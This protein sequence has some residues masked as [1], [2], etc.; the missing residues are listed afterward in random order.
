MS[1]RGGAD[2][3]GG[4]PPKRFVLIFFLHIINLSLFRGEVICEI[5][6]VSATDDS[7]SDIPI[8]SAT[9][10]SSDSEVSSF[11]SCPFPALTGC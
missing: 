7:D 3:G 4:G 9:F 6:L 10:S 1:K 8:Q 2:K 11:C 5:D